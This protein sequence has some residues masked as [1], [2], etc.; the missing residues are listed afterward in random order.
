LRYTLAAGLILASD[1][2][3][4]FLVMRHMTEGQSIPLLPPLLYVTYVQN[5][6]AAFGFLQGQTVLLSAIALLCLLF[7]STQWK[8]IMAKSPFVRCGV[9]IALMGAIGN[10]IDRLRW[11]AVIDFVDIRIFVF[12]VADTA[13]VAGVG[14]LFWEVL[15]HDRKEG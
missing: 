3:S 11:G 1:R 13:I 7:I 5:R 12:N 8:K 9:V 15:I 6:G 14:L 2:I 4:K 10:L